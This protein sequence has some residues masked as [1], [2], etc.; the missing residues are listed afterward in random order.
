M[1]RKEN[2]M[3][4]ECV[5]YIRT[6]QSL[7]DELIRLAAID[8]RSQNSMGEKLLSIGM[9]AWKRKGKDAT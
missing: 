3:K 6:A 4:D 5:I 7:K 9:K 8:D 2:G 1:Q